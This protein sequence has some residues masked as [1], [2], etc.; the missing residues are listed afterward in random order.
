MEMDDLEKF[1]DFLEYI[2]KKS[3]LYIGIDPG[4][5]GAIG[6]I[7]QANKEYVLDIPCE[8]VKNGKKYRSVFDYGGIINIF[9]LVY[10]YTKASNAEVIVGLEDIPMSLGP[11]RKTA[12][13][14]LNRAH[15]IWPLFLMSKRYKIID[16][17]PQVWKKCFGLLKKDKSA[18]RLIAQK[19]FPKAPLHLKKHVDRAEA[20]LIAEYTRRLVEHN[21]ISS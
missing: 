4:V 3:I 6:F 16:I 1:Q 21:A 5:S 15:A 2:P 8:K 10:S 14:M 12:E 7:N 17:R 20:L 19:M 18:S 11:G 9:K 13:I